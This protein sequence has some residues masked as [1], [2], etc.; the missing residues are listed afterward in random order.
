MSGLLNKTK[1]NTPGPWQ[2]ECFSVCY[3]WFVMSVWVKLTRS[4]ISFCFHFSH[5]FICRWP[6]RVH[7]LTTD[8]WVT[9]I[10]AFLVC[11]FFLRELMVA[12]CWV[13][14]QKVARI[15]KQH[16][17]VQLIHWNSLKQ[18]AMSSPLCVF[19]GLK[20]CILTLNMLELKRGSHQC[21]S[22]MMSRPKEAN[23][24]LSRC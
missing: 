3:Q 11:L 14:R 21:F 5:P 15:Q 17:L 19:H 1:R 6:M 8:W 24:I 2:F 22:K 12:K 18:K 16:V 13:L 10:W 9:S 4:S 20:S 7:G 23:K